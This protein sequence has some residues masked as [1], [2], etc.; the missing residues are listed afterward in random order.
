VTSLANKV[1][2]KKGGGLVPAIVQ[3][4]VTGRVLMLGYMNE[5]AFEKTQSS[6]RVTFYSRTRECLWTKGETSGNTLEL[7]DQEIDCDGDTILI[8][9]FPGGPTCHLDKASCFDGDAGDPGFGFIGQL[10][11]TI[12]DRMRSQ[13]G[14]SYTAELMRGGVQRIAQKI[15]EEGVEL[16]LAATQDNH[17]EV[18]SE[19][20]DLLYHVMVLLRHEGMTFADVARELERRHR[21]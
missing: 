4:A 10:E 3:H 20:A 9:A 16:A 5:E 14:D 15:G 11:S 19:A 21:A 13:P 18:I 8:Q 12:N 6:K 1:D 17:A 2:W 7:S